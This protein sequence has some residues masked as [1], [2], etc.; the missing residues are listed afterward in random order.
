[1]RTTL[2]LCGLYEIT[3]RNPD[4]SAAW[5]DKV[6]NTIVTAGLTDLLS[7]VFNGGTQKTSWYMSLI[8]NT[9]FD[10]ITVDDTMSSHAGWQELTT[11]SGGSRK[12]WTPLS[13]SSGIIIN[14]SPIQFVMTAA[15]VIKGFFITSDSTLSGTS[16]IL[17]SAASFTTAR[18]VQSGQS[19]TVKYTLRAAGGS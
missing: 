3:C 15:A 10:Q 2:K 13:V 11:Y 9:S 1:M 6:W 7:A 16:G 17:M 12:Q 19:L 4:G 5:R 18:T 8:N 14:T